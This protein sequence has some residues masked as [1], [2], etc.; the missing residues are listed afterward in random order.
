MVRVM[1]VVLL[2]LIPAAGLA[3]AQGEESVMG[4][5]EGTYNATDGSGTLT[6]KI[7]ALGDNRF[8]GYIEAKDRGMKFNLRGVNFGSTAAFV[9]APNDDGSQPEYTISA[10]VIDGAMKGRVLDS[11]RMEVATFRMNKVFIQSPTLGEAPPEGAIALWQGPDDAGKWIRTRESG[12]SL[13]V[14]GSTVVTK[15]EF[16][17]HKLHLEFKTPFMPEER[18]QGRG[19]SGVYV[20]GRYEVQVLDSFGDEPA[21]NLCG[22][23]YRQAVPV[24][25][26]CLPPGEWQTYDIT[27][28]APR[29][30]ASGTKTANA[31][32]T[33]VHNGEVIHDALELSDAT[34][35][36]VSGTEAAMGPL[37]LQ[38]HND[39]VEFRNI[40][41]QPR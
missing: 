28:T 6:G 9:S 35:G 40:W 10:E 12:G 11:A 36:G 3:F 13:T 37:L 38:D 14:G 21:D 34:P 17:D 31:V 19:N 1:S 26:A 22:G 25:N 18:G 16:G 23:I 2:A 27:F 20:F 15:E 29:F 39:R 30:D 24:T 4:N 33:V 5:W 8:G 7:I 32:I 41:V